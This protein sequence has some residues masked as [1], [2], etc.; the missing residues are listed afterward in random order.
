MELDH[1]AEN[2]RPFY[3]SYLDQLPPGTPAP[4]RLDVWYFCDSQPCADELGQLA[5]QGVKTATASLLWTY[6]KTGEPL[7]AAGQLSLI[8][9]WSGQPLCILE[10]TRVY[11]LPFNQVDAEQAYQEGEGDRSLA[12]WREAHWRFFGREC[13]AL[14][15]EPAEEMPVVCE[16]FRLVFPPLQ[17]G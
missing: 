11:I 1:L 16:R 3:Q 17:P 12:Y 15:R 14:G 2:L 9:T 4:A 7:P 8:T 13:A 5:L 10:T 6:E